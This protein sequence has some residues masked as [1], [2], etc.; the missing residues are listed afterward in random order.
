MYAWVFQV[1]AFPGFPTETCIR[2]SSPIRV[3][4]PAHLILLLPCNIIILRG[5]GLFVP[6]CSAR[7]SQSEG[8]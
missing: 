2:L 7:E 5:C 6:L 3:T 4:F 1:V 8:C